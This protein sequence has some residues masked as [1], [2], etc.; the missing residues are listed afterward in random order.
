M[1]PKI[2]LLNSKHGRS[3]VEEYINKPTGPEEGH[4]HGF[5]TLLL[6]FHIITSWTKEKNYVSQRTSRSEKEDTSWK[7]C[8][9]VVHGLFHFPLLSGRGVG[10]LPSRAPSSGRAFSF[11]NS[12]SPSLSLCRSFDLTHFI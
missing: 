1:S 5:V 6:V 7:I 11:G 12:L 3:P 8:H 10:V 9:L 4:C 2:M